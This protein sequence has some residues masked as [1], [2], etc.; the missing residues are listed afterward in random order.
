MEDGKDTLDV[1]FVWNSPDGITYKKI[2][3]FSRN[4]YII[5]IKYKV[6]NT[7]SNEWVGYQYNQFKTNTGRF[8]EFI[9]SSNHGSKLYRRSNL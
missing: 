8:A 5:D 9:Q 6:F 1:E 2:Y 7:S 3:T 4:S